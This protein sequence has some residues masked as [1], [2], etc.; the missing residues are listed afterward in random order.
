MLPLGVDIT[1]NLVYI[2]RSYLHMS[3][4]EEYASRKIGKSAC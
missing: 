1:Y 2:E 4:G 3:K